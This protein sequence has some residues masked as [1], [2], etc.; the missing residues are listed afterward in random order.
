MGNVILND[1]QDQTPVAPAAPKQAR[2]GRGSVGRLIHARYDAAVVDDDNRRHWANAD[3]LSARQ[4][5]STVV[6]ERLRNHSRYEVANNCYARGMVNTLADVTVGY[7]PNITFKRPPKASRA[8]VEALRA[9]AKLFNAWAEEIDLWGKL[10]TMRVSKCQDGEAFAV[11]RNN[12]R[13]EAVELDLQLVEAEQVTDGYMSVESLDPKKVD[14]IETDDMGNPILYRVLTEHPGDGA[15]WD[16]DVIEIPASQ[17]VHWFRRDRPGQLRGIPEITPAL[18]LFSQLRRLTLATLTAA[19]TAADIAALIES[20]MTPDDDESETEPF[21]T[22]EINR[23]MMT[24]L[25]DGYKMSQMKAEHPT[26]TYE[27]FKREI[28][29]EAGR[30][31]GFPKLLSLMD[32][33]G[34]NYSSG[35]LDKQGTDRSI[36]VDRYGCELH[37]LR[38]VFDAWFYEALLMPGFLPELVEAGME[39]EPKWLWRELGHVDRKK[40][41]DGA[42]Q[43]MANNTTT[44]A[45]ECGR[46]GEDWEEILEQRAAELARVR[47]LGLGVSTVARPQGEENGNDEQVATSD[48]EQDDADSETSGV[49]SSADDAD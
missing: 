4:A 13:L 34:Y 18:P 29:C 42:A 36:D 33:S 45:I 17:I 25:P 7:G 3:S 10:W 38:K 46:Q 28:L 6:R 49:G 21:E 37:V 2:R 48:D 27:M 31:I 14:G 16:H 30:C 39:V 43:D 5:N 23:G 41:A 44:L 9:T 15:P 47:E 40:E 22:I 35:R 20:T 11:F 19:E 1:W 24:T 12:P 8:Q 32:A 26:T